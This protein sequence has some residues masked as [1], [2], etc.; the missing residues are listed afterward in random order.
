MFFLIVANDLLPLRLLLRSPI[1]G[2]TKMFQ[3][4][5]RN[6]EL[7]ILGPAEM[8]FCFLDGFFTR[9]VA[10]GFARAGSRHPVSDGGFDENQR[11]FGGNGLCFSDSTFNFIQI[12]S[13]FDCRSVPAVGVKASA[14]V[15][16]ESEF[17]ET[18][19][20][21]LIVVVKVN[22]FSQLQM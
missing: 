3:R 14:N 10:V 8:S 16:G 17:S 7:F 11:W 15:F 18:F 2:G 5:V 13:V 6:V 22:E 19:D 20:C 9:S 21:H 4:L 1:D 12:V